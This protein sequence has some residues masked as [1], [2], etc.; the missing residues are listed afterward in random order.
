MY[1][2]AMD[3]CLLGDSSSVTAGGKYLHHHWHVTV[4]SAQLLAGCT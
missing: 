4:D 1:A 3:K 2:R